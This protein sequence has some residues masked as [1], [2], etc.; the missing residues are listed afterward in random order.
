[1]VCLTSVDLPAP[2]GPSS[3]YT[4]PGS[5]ERDAVVGGDGAEVLDQVVD[6][7]GPPSVGA[8]SRRGIIPG[9]PVPARSGAATVTVNRPARA[10]H[11]EPRAPLRRSGGARR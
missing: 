8:C 10:G 11:P 5:T 3:P 4:S 1:M 7:E 6:A 9:A 2:L